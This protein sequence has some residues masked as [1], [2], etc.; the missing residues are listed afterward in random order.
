MASVNDSKP[1]VT[2]GKWEATLLNIRALKAEIALLKKRL[3][4]V[5]KLTVGVSP[6]LKRPANFD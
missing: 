5:E 2:R 3:L 4:R 1:V 6:L